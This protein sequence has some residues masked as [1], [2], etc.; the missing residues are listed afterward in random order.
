MNER[1]VA[2][3]NFWLHSLTTPVPI[4]F[5][6]VLLI[7]GHSLV[8]HLLPHYKTS[9]SLAPTASK[10]AMNLVLGLTQNKLHYKCHTS[11]GLTQFL[12]I[13]HIYNICEKGLL[14]SSCTSIPMEQFCSHLMDI[15]EI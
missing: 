3:S 2:T 4:F 15:H 11:K 1:H 13:R 12:I 6:L 14:A 9:V 10:I 5:A 8:L 7:L